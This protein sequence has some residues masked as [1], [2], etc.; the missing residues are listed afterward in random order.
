MANEYD[1][2]IKKLAKLRVDRSK[3]VAPHKPLL[4]LVL[5]ELAKSGVLSDRV[6]TL[7]P[8]LAFRFSVYWSIVAHRRS[9]PPDVRLPFYHTASSKLW[10][11][12]KADGTA[13]GHRESTASIRLADPFFEALKSAEFRQ[14]AGYTLISNYFEHAEQ[15]AI[16]EL[17]GITPPEDSTALDD[18]AIQADKEARAEGRSARFRVDVV[19]AYCHTCAL[20]G[21]RVTTI[22]GHSIV[23]AAHIH[24][25]ARSRNDD[26]QNGIA[27]CKNAHWL[28]DLG[29]WSIDDDYR[30]LVA[31]DAFDEACPTQ[32]SLRSLVGNRLNLPRD[33]TLWPT[34]KNIQWHR[35]KCFLGAS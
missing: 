29:L 11:T 31:R 13:S 3:G 34:T 27:L 9:Q 33:Q 15:I 16:Y 19:A 30:V 20:T 5:L 4:L 6:L 17:A 18:L 12:H 32:D 14:A 26:P 1:K 24:Q 35:T 2:L 23:D 25:F 21:Y 8:D 7:T 10:T 22:T 28:F